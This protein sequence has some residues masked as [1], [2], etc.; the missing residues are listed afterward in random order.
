MIF[1]P[2]YSSMTNRE[3]LAS[4][5]LPNTA[6]GYIFQSLIMFEGIG[7]GLTW[8]NIT[9]TV[10]PDDKMC[11]ADIMMMLVFDTVLYLLVAVYLETAFPRNS[12]FHPPW[13]FPIM[14]R[15]TR[16]GF[17]AVPFFRF[18]VIPVLTTTAFSFCF[19]YMFRA[20]PSFWFAKKVDPGHV[21]GKSGIQIQSLSK[22]FTQGKYVVNKLSVD[23]HPNQITVLL[24]HNGAG[25][26]TTMSML[27]GLISPTSGTALIEGYDIKTHMKT[28]RNSLGLCPQYNLLIPDLTVHEHLYFFGMVSVYNTMGFFTFFIISL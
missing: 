6:L 22:S 17:A 11:I 28:I 19:M 21:V 4:T 20:Q 16:G 7:S 24:G 3:I 23:M 25:K 27:T 8:D 9:V 12:G 15:G 13:Y 10:S 2:K 18:P 14:V 26:S 5:V 1:Q